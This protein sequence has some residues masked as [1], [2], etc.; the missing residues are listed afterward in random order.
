MN[1]I[2][3]DLAYNKT[4]QNFSLHIS[5][6]KTTYD[7]EHLNIYLVFSITI[8]DYFKEHRY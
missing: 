1:Y 5:N 4:T 8:L 2:N 6:R 3:L 7:F